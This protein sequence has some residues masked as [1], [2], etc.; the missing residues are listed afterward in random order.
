MKTKILIFLVVLFGAVVAYFAYAYVRQQERFELV[1][2]W[3]FDP[4]R[5]PNIYQWL[6]RSFVFLIKRPEVIDPSNYSMSQWEWG[7][8]TY[9]LFVIERG[10]KKVVCRSFSGL[11]IASSTVDLEPFVNKAVLIT[12][13][14]IKEDRSFHVE[15]IELDKAT[16]DRIDE[17]RA[18][19]PFPF[20]RMDE[21]GGV[22][23]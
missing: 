17:Y 5:G 2:N 13:F 4:A 11:N 9:G 15:H 23:Q 22:R 19:C 8:Y 14:D 10:S 1:E 21:I 3:N 20:Q 12:G 7:S 6:S 18:A 16:N